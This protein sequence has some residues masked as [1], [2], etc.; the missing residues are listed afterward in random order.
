MAA[1]L[2][3]SA[4]VGSEFFYPYS[5]GASVSK[6]IVNAVDAL[7]MG[8]PATHEFRRL[9][10][11]QGVTRNAS[12]ITAGVDLSA[13]STSPHGSPVL[14]T[15]R[16]V[17]W[18]QHTGA[19]ASVA[20]MRPDGSI[21]IKNIVSTADI[22]ETAHLSGS[23]DIRIGLLESAV[24]GITPAKT[25]PENFVT[26]FPGGASQPTDNSAALKTFYLPTL[27]LDVDQAG[28]AGSVLSISSGHQIGTWDGIAAREFYDFCPPLYYARPTWS[29]WGQQVIEGDSGGVHFW[30]INGELCYLGNTFEATPIAPYFSGYFPLILKKTAINQAM[31]DLALAYDGDAFAYALTEQDWSMFTT[32]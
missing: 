30:V 3:I 31:R 9:W 10:T 32:L 4:P 25:P 1:Q 29:D 22:P 18:A 15:A 23:S 17:A 27:Y 24:T 13:L 16:H 19:R 28:G 12:A 8:K 14:I 2:K 5:L 6:H 26:K 11:Q 21:T 7:I 20:F